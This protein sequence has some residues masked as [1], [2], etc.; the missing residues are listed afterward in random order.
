MPQELFKFKIRC[1]GIGQIMTD[2]R[3]KTKAE[4]LAALRED[5]ERTKARHDELRDGLVSKQKLA[6]KVQELYRQILETEQQPEQVEI[7]ETAKTFCKNWLKNRLYDRRKEF[8]S[9][10]TEKGNKVEFEAMQYAEQVFGWGFT[11]PCD[12]PKEND[13]MTGFCDI[14]RHKANF[15]HDIKCSWDCYTFPLFESTIP[16]AE[17]EWQVLG[18]MHLYNVENA[19]V[20]Y[21]LMDMPEELLQKECHY[22][23]GYN[24]TKEQYE[25]MKERH[26]Y[27]HL[28]DHLRI[29]EYKFTYDAEKIEKIKTR[30]AEC[31]T[32]I[33]TLTDGLQNE[34]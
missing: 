11:T 27:S 1:S 33:N 19:S 29:K 20:I 7:S 16:D 5:F 13:F 34:Q 18:Y 25:E 17:Y 8:K 24:F 26:T 4:K 22:K 30:V 3:G 10:Y 14:L 21:C 6:L 23:Y 15:V 9:K 31:Q 12:E 28:P 32:Y 2:G